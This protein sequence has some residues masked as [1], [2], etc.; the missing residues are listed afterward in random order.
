[1]DA[2]SDLHSGFLK[3]LENQDQTDVVFKLGTP[4]NFEL[5]HAHKLVLGAVS[6]VFKTMFSVNWNAKGKPI[7]IKNF[8]ANSFKMFIK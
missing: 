6:P 2:L 1:M 3:M 7:E 5:F 4:D 8:D